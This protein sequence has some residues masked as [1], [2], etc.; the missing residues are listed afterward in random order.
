MF[1]KSDAF[2]M[3]GDIRRKDETQIDI[4]AQQYLANVTVNQL[5]NHTILAFCL[6]IFLLV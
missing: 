5:E 6:P 2:I 4:F 1:E 3:D